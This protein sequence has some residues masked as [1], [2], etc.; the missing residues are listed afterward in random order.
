M[1]NFAQPF[2]GQLSL[3]IER[4]V[5]EEGCGEARTRRIS[6]TWSRGARDAPFSANRVPTT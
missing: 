6:A 3:A 1:R 4:L 5:S 2:S